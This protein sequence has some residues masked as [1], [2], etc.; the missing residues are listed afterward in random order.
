MELIDAPALRP[1]AVGLL[2]AA[3]TGPA[4]SRMEERGFQSWGCGGYRVR[5][6]CSDE[7][8]NQSWTNPC[9]NV[10]AE[11]FFVETKVTA[12]RAGSDPA[13]LVRAATAKLEAVTSA[14]IARELWTNELTTA[15]VD[16]EFAH[17]TLVGASDLNAAGA[18]DPKRAQ[19]LLEDYL[20]GL[21]DGPVGAIHAT[22][23]AASVLPE[24]ERVGNVITTSVGTTIIPD[25]GYTGTS[26]AGA[27][28][29]AGTSWV[30][31]TSL[32]IVSL[33]PIDTLED[34]DRAANSLVA[35]ATR[36]V[37]VAFECG[38]AAVRMNLA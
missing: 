15:V 5:A 23:G 29:A 2:T 36:P 6:S 35:V 10:R 4:L 3:A 17:P 24:K 8:A 22:R 12:S 25:A 31:A 9:S 19:A 18:V 20:A 38:S 16:A 1:P 30:Y 37:W 26:P 11:P 21:L 7:V 33:G 13:E 27:A 34:F 14:A 28:P 32:P